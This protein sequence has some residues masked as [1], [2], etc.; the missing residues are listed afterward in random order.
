MHEC[1][2]LSIDWMASRSCAEIMQER[3]ATV[4]AIENAAESF[5]ISGLCESWFADCDV[6]VKR[7][8]EGV[9]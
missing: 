6:H 1:N 3:E 4:I 7:V 2:K 5:G 9:N 8:S